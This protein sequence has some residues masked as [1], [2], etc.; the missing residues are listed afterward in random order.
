MADTYLFDIGPSNGVKEA[1][2][3]IAK[4]ANG[5]PT[6]VYPCLLGHVAMSYTTPTMKLTAT[7]VDANYSFVPNAMSW[8][9]GAMVFDRENHK[10]VYTI[11]RAG[12][13]LFYV[14]KY[15]SASGWR[16]GWETESNYVYQN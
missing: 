8:F 15:K 13:D 9:D 16:C 10:L 6:L 11:R 2:E 12:A 14:Y 5:A 1:M 4:D 7:T 3:A